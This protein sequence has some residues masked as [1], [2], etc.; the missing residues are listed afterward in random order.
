MYKK[1]STLLVLFIALLYAH[2]AFG[3]ELKCKVD[4]NSQQIQGTDKRIYDN[5]KKVV[6][7]YMNTT[8]FTNLEL[9]NEEKIECSLMFIVKSKEGNSH[10]CEFQIQSSRPVYGSNYSTT[11]LNFRENITFEFQES[12]TLTFNETMV[13]DNLTAS[14]DFWAYLIIGLDFDSFSKLGGNTFFQKA[15]AISSM[16]Q[17]SLGENWKAQQ[18]RNNWGWINVLTNTT[19]PEMRLL[20]YQ[21]HRLGL[22]QMYKDT[23]SGRSNILEALKL[24]KSV[25][26]AKPRSPQLANFIETKS[27][28]LVNV[29]SKATK[30]EKQS[31]YELL[32]TI[33]PT[34][35]NK[36]QGLLNSN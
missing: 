10:T 23:E 35:S 6:Q 4:V 11:L 22:D 17:G 33:Y 13:N 28:E 12:Q 32:T 34:S 25:K 36:L 21:Y 5:L 14:L 24:L 15:Q 29:F 8:R 19:Q 7:D 31:A 20:S 2:A 18:D 9:E 27:S 3:Q 16:A 30:S 26:Q 1:L